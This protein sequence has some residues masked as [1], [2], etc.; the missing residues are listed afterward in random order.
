MKRLSLIV[1][2]LTFSLLSIQCGGE[3]FGKG[4]ITFQL[5]V[6]EITPTKTYVIYSGE[7]T[8]RNLNIEHGRSMRIESLNDEEGKV[9]YI[10]S[11][12]STGDSLA[13]MTTEYF[14]SE[15]GRKIKSITQ[16]S[17]WEDVI[18]NYVAQFGHKDMV[19]TIYTHTY[20]E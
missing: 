6:R 11:V 5:N 14:Q 10:T 18:E 2:L 4:K 1:L 3:K 8:D 17:L 20:T 9:Y 12:S 13:T 16:T 19:V 15:S 7:A